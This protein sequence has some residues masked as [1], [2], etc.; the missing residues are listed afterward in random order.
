MAVRPTGHRFGKATSARSSCNSRRAGPNPWDLD[1]GCCP[2]VGRVDAAPV[3]ERRNFQRAARSAGA[4][5]P[6]KAR[7][8]VGGGL[9]LEILLQRLPGDV[10]R[11]LVAL[12]GEHPQPAAQALG[13]AEGERDGLVSVAGRFGP[14]AGGGPAGSASDPW[15]PWTAR[16]A[17]LADA[18]IRLGNWS[19]TR[20]TSEA[21][22]CGSGPRWGERR[23][24][25]RRRTRPRCGTGR[26]STHCKVAWSGTRG[27]SPSVAWGAG[28]D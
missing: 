25:R 28:G 13:A 16:M 1:A 15:G 4:D 8:S 10:L 27:E 22:R 5:L 24:A 12:G 11:R 14:R 3:T 18:T 7:F 23:L 6:D 26:G 9:P 17:G 21:A 19:N 2:V 20:A